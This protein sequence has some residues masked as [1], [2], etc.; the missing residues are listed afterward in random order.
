MVLLGFPVYDERGWDQRS[1]HKIDKKFVTQFDSDLLLERPGS[2]PMF[3]RESLYLLIFFDILG[4]HRGLIGYVRSILD[5]GPATYE[6]L[7]LRMVD[8]SIP[9]DIFFW[10]VFVIAKSQM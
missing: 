6:L 10:Y 3:S 1:L 5:N 9:V 2:P 8:C 4:D 7:V